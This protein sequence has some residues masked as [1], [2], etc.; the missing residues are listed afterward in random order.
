VNNKGGA[1]LFCAT[2]DNL[3]IDTTSGFIAHIEQMIDNR[4][5]A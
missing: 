2:Q 1:D 3:A 4:C 5:P